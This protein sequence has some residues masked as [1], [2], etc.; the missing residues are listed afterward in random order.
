MNLAPGSHKTPQE[1]VCIMDDWLRLFS[2]RV[3]VVGECWEWT[4]YVSRRGYGQLRRSPFASMQVHRQSLVI[5]TGADRPG[6]D[7]RHL[8]NNRRC[9]RPS[10]LAW[11]TRSENMADCTAAGR[12][13]KPRG[14]SHWT[15]KLSAEDVRVL[16]QRWA[17]GES[18]SALAREFGVNAATVSRI[19]RKE[20]R[21]EVA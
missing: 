18:Q 4:G 1:G 14:E 17:N 20:W 11:G 3:E 7:A 5:A 16:R 2:S 10:H 12:H 8:C 6:L 13:N 15:A 9:V 19:V 21:R